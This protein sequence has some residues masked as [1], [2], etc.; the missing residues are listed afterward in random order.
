MY[1]YMYTEYNVHI[2][3]YCIYNVYQYMYVHCIYMYTHIYMHTV[4]VCTDPGS[5]VPMFISKLW[6]YV[7]DQHGL[8]LGIVLL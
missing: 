8:Q 1:M 6:K 4:H 2:S 5:H 7:G 3:I